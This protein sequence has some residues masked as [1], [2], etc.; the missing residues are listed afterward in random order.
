MDAGTA[1][2]QSTQAGG[3]V[4]DLLQQEKTT[5]EPMNQ[6]VQADSQK[7]VPQPDLKKAPSTPDP[8]GLMQDATSW[9]AT[10]SVLSGLGGAFSRQHA[11]MGLDA[12]AAGLNGFTKGKMD[13]FKEQTATWKEANQSVI[14]N[15]KAQIEQYKSAMQ[16]KKLSIDEQMAEIKTVASQYHNDVL[17]Q[18]AEQKNFTLVARTIDI[19]QSNNDK[20]ALQVQ[21]LQQKIDATTG[22]LKASETYK[23][24]YPTDP[25]TGKRDPNAPPFMQWIKTD[26][27]KM[28]GK[29]EGE[30]DGTAADPGGVPAVPVVGSGGNKKPPTPPAA[31]KRVTIYK[32]GKP[33]GT[34]PMEQADQATQEGYTLA[35]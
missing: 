11:T 7:Q 22:A 10:L 9:V 24:I 23:N 20:L 19:M 16:D 31:G 30:D 18:A 21:G 17:A 5:L 8:S 1:L 13:A 25:T 27:P 34:V 14:E 2:Q 33:A 32:D 28:N 12:F 3:N 26:W 6:K 35:P 4:G 29:A 15:N